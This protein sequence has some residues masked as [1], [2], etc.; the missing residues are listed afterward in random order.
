[1]KMVDCTDCAA[2]AGYV[3]T[4]LE[5]RKQI[6]VFLDI[7]HKLPSVEDPVHLSVF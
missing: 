2:V 4:L 1:M 6:Q 7:G 3:G 5:S